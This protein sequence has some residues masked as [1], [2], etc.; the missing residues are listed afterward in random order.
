MMLQNLMGLGGCTEYDA[1]SV[2]VAFDP[3]TPGD[4]LTPTPKPPVSGTPVV[5]LTIYRK[6]VV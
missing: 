2:C 3:T 4:N 1:N 5:P 6:S